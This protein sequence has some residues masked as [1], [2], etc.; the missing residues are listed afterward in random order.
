MTAFL[1]AMEDAEHKSLFA[2]VADPVRD[3]P[4]TA[5]K[6]DAQAG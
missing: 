2:H 3:D 5:E 6:S 1:A 4:E